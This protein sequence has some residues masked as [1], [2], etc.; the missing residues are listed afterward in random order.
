MYCA[1]GI[2]ETRVYCLDY[3]FNAGAANKLGSVDV[4]TYPKGN[5]LYSYTN[6]LEAKDE[7]IGIAIQPLVSRSLS[8]PYEAANPLNPQADESWMSSKAKKV[9]ALLYA[10]PQQRRC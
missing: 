9:K 4:Y 8:T 6:G 2:R 3:S 5:Y 7:P 10:M 1:L